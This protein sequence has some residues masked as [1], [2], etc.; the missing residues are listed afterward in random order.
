MKLNQYIDH[1]LLK[2]EAVSAD[3]E[4]LC[5]EAR[6]WDFI[7][8]C[9]PPGWVAFCK[10]TLGTAAT[11]VATVVGFPLGY[12]LATTKIA[13][14]RELLAL[15]ADELDMVLNISFLKAGQLREVENEIRDIKTL[16]PDKIL[17]VI[18]ETSLLSVVEKRTACEIAGRCGVDFVKTSTGFSGGGA[19][20]ADVRLMKENIPARMQVKASG[21]IRDLATAQAMIAAG[22][23]R[24]GTS[25]G[26]ALM[27]G[28]TA[29]GGY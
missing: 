8:V 25:G 13:E 18:F 19:T 23:T 22:A 12:S 17:K 24:L 2:P 21:G 9:V 16:M 6:E 4:R 7:S 14:A 5:E 3:Y 29:A 20:V 27:K 15:G 1:T 26:V 28:L 11:K 10:E